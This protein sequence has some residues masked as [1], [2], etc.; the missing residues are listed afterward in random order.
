MYIHI[1]IYILVLK[2]YEQDFLWV[3]WI[4]RHPLQLLAWEPRGTA[5]APTR[6]RRAPGVAAASRGCSR[7]LGDQWRG[8]SKVKSV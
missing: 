5:R 8:R 4:P 6:P 1:Y 3:I 2:V 7:V